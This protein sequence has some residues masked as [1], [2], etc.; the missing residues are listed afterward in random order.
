[1]IKDH[2]SCRCVPTQPPHR[3][4]D[5][6]AGTD[7]QTPDAPP[8]GH[9]KADFTRT[10]SGSV[11]L[12]RSTTVPQPPASLPTHRAGRFNAHSPTGTGAV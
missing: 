5:T 8:N 12:L 6:V 2:C 11:R 3:R 1:M 10:Q 7:W 9:V 4:S